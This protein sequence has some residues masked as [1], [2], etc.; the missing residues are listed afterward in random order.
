VY[1]KVGFLSSI[2]TEMGKHYS[3]VNVP[4]VVFRSRSLRMCTFSVDGLC[5]LAFDGVK[6]SCCYEDYLYRKRNRTRNSDSLQHMREVIG[7]TL[8]TVDIVILIKWAL[9]GWYLDRKDKCKHIYIA[10]LRPHPHAPVVVLIIIIR[11]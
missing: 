5:K 10:V 4:V 3:T 9:E 2:F 11:T 8:K 6:R 7:T 1:L